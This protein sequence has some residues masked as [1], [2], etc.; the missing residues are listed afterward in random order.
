MEFQIRGIHQLSGCRQS[1]QSTNGLAGVSVR[2]LAAKMDTNV[3][4]VLQQGFRV[5][6]GVSSSVGPVGE[7]GVPE[8]RD[9]LWPI[10]FWPIHFF[11]QSISGSGVCVSWWG[12]KGWGPNP[13]KMGPEGWGPEGWGAQNFAFFFFPP[14]FSFLLSL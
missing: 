11:G 3:V 7:G 13:E 6:F 8:G 10:L 2:R 9:Q 12:P 1:T 5:F 4:G 14:P